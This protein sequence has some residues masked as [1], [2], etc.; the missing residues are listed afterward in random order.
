MIFIS[1]S[2]PQG[3]CPERFWP[4]VKYSWRPLVYSYLHLSLQC[5]TTF[6][7]NNKTY[8]ILFIRSLQALP[9][10]V[11]WF[12]S[13]YVSFMRFN[14]LHLPNLFLFHG[15]CVTL[16]KYTMFLTY[17]RG[18]TLFLPAFHLWK[19]KK[20][21][22]A[23]GTRLMQITWLWNAIPV[24][25]KGSCIRLL[26]KHALTHKRKHVC[27]HAGLYLQIQGCITVNKGTSKIKQRSK[28]K[29]I[30][31]SHTHALRETKKKAANPCKGIHFLF[32]KP[33]ILL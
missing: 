2:G 14:V 29:K 22:L 28:H 27:N 24:Q 9:I 32:Y 10:T 1:V 19:K 30:T 15:N 21:T 12:F 20:N 7:I 8:K 17:H 16:H 26:F 25:P 6:Y 23:V 33:L 18:C 4:S 13:F 31:N 5:L 11:G 3:V